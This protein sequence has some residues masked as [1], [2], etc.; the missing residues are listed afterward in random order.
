MAPFRTGQ[1]RQEADPRPHAAATASSRRS[2]RAKQGS[3]GAMVHTGRVNPCYSSGQRFSEPSSDLQRTR[4]ANGLPLRGR[5][6]S[7]GT[8]ESERQQPMILRAQG[9]CLAVVT[10]VTVRRISQ[11]S[12]LSH[13]GT[14]SPTKV[15]RM[16]P[17]PPLAD[18][19][20]FIEKT[21]LPAMRTVKMFRGCE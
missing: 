6:A 16:D 2:M 17:Q 18:E 3:D 14:A 20:F 21:F 15:L 12:L 11:P 1:L 19:P 7:V 4:T 5:R 8:K 10:C 13:E 9:D